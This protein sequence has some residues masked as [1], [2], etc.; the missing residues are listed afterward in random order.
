MNKLN[1]WLAVALFIGGVAWV[2]TH[3]VFWWVKGGLIVGAYCLGIQWLKQYSP[4]W[5]KFIAVTTIQII[6]AFI[7]GILGTSGRRGRR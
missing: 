3:P 6:F 2:V 5:A 4:Y 1:G 7:G